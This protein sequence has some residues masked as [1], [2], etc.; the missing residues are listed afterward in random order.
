MNKILN[1]IQKLCKPA[2][3]YFIISVIS[4][5]AMLMQNC[6][7]GSSY[8]IGTFSAES[9][10]HPAT[11][12]IMKA[13]YILAWTY[14]LNLLCKNGL[15]TVSWAIVLLPVLGM[16]L[17]I[18]M[19]MFALLR[20]EGFEEGAD[21]DDEEETTG[22]FATYEG[23]K[24][25]ADS[26][27]EGSGFENEGMDHDGED[28]R[29]INPR[30]APSIEGMKTK[31]TEEELAA[32]KKWDEGQNACVE[33]FSN[34]E[35][36]REGTG[37]QCKDDE[38]WNEEKGKCVKSEGFSLREGNDQRCAQGESWD[39]NE[40]KCVENFYTNEGFKEGADSDDEGSGFENEGYEGDVES[41][42]MGGGRWPQIGSLM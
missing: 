1:Q 24:E 32:G 7:D 36:F 31:C 17:I 34:Y 25:G 14:G 13:I 26:D 20:R 9:P 28:F 15:K 39:E 16:F 33:G 29:P 21:T 3:V 42:Q 41:F 4:F 18:G 40:Q 12:F 19:L 30:G 22:G 2:Q 27:D 11:F 23:F 8:N 6:S 38:V 10:C 37:N 5:L 35:G